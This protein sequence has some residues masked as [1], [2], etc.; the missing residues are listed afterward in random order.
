MVRWSERA[1]QLSGPACEPRS[2]R[3]GQRELRHRRGPKYLVWNKLQHGPA[4]PVEAEVTGHWVASRFNDRA[5]SKTC[6]AA[7]MQTDY[8]KSSSL[9]R[10]WKAPIERSPLHCSLNGTEGTN[11][12]HS[13]GAH[14]SSRTFSDAE[15][16][17][18]PEKIDAQ[19]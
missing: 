2:Q 12:M 7:Q 1:C 15:A 9:T 4:A 11:L 18:S 13:S 8:G 19:S 6:T 10:C 5:A 3:R 17:F 16:S 14:A